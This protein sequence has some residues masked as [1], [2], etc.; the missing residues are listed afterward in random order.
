MLIQFCSDVTSESQKLIMAHK[1]GNFMIH[2]ETVSGHHGHKPKRPQR[3]R[4]QTET[5]TDQK[6]TNRNGHKQEQTQTETTT[7]R[8][9]HKPKRPQI[10]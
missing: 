9:G 2:L 3:K 10:T 1:I 5:A 7:D 8:N 6:A 4:P